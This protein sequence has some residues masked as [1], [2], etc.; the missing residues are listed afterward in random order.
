M[1]NGKT[2]VSSSDHIQSHFPRLQR[3]AVVVK[4]VKSWVFCVVVLARGKQGIPH[5][6]ACLKG[7]GSGTFS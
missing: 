5:P 3:P 7:T 6:V 2:A 4:V 1:I